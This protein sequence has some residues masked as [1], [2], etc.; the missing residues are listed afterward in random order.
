MASAAALGAA[1]FYFAR[2]EPWHDC[3]QRTVEIQELGTT[4]RPSE[5]FVLPYDFDR[6]ME[7]VRAVE[8]EM[9]EGRI[10]QYV[11]NRCGPKPQPE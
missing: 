7:N 9:S 4:I 1:T 10:P 5:G 3:A 2:V 6:K 8:K 11:I